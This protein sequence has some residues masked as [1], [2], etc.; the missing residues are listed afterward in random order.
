MVKG[1]TYTLDA[2]LQIS[3]LSDFHVQKTSSRMGINNAMEWR[4]SIQ[5]SLAHH[6]NSLKDNMD[7]QM[8]IV[9]VT[10]TIE[11]YCQPF[12]WQKFYIMIRE[13]YPEITIQKC[14]NLAN[15]KTEKTIRKYSY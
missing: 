3:R 11:R 12:I 14:K 4:K 9:H 8:Q 5:R 1:F 10:Q 13:K 2:L 6:R 15:D 7:I